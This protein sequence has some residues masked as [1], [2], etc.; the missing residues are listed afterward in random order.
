MKV[1]HFEMFKIKR[2]PPTY[3]EAKHIK[4]DETELDKWMPEP[5]PMDKDDYRQMLIMK[6]VDSDLYFNLL[7]N[8]MS[9]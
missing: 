8:K 6:A 2:R 1:D 9:L 7:F 4:E 3:E 5:M